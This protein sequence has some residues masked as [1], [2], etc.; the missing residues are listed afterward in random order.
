MVSA[1]ARKLFTY[2]SCSYHRRYSQ[3]YYDHACR[4]EHTMKKLILCA[5]FLLCAGCSVHAEDTTESYTAT[6]IENDGQSAVLQLEDAETD[7]DEY[8][9]ENNV[10]KHW[11]KECREG[12]F[13]FDK[14]DDVLIIDDDRMVSMDE[15]GEH[16]KTV[17]TFGKGKAVIQLID[18]QEDQEG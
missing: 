9:E 5:V 16:D 6:V 10:M 7:S 11:N 18:D 12:T 13:R 4:K 8:S 15:L 14:D 1:Y 3:A 2:C 17:V